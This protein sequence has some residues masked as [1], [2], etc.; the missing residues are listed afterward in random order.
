MQWTHRPANMN[1]QLFHNPPNCTTGDPTKEYKLATP[2]QPTR[3]HRRRPRHFF[4]QLMLVWGDTED[5]GCSGHTC[6][7]IRTSSPKRDLR[8]RMQWTHRPANMNSQLFHNPPNCTTGDPT[9]E[10][11]LATPPQPT[12]RHRRRPRHFFPQLMLV[13]G[14]TEDVGCSGHT[15]L[16]IRTSNLA[17]THPTAPSDTPPRN[18]YPY[19][20]QEEWWKE[21]R[22]NRAIGK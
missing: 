18:Q 7:P 8:R 6:L 20:R 16:P 11:K 22:M 4:P 14:D 2:P 15:C 13:W 10:Y 9:K 12:R 1:S 19:Y 3:R 17:S 5:V 21:L